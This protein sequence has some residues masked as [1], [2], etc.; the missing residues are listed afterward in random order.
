LD[1]CELKRKIVVYVKDEGSNLNTMTTTF[2]SIV[3]YDVFGLEE[4][5]QRTCFGHAFFETCIILNMQQTNENFNNQV[6]KTRCENRLLL[7]IRKLPYL[8]I[9]WVWKNSKSWYPGQ[10]SPAYIYIYI[11]ELIKFS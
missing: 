2:K 10:F 3:S 4:N 7:Y 1:T 5:F 11:W 8:R 6:V 9:G